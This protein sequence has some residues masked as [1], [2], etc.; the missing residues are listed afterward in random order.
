MTSSTSKHQALIYKLFEKTNNKKVNWVFD[1]GTP[2]VD[3][4]ING[5]LISLEKKS[6]LNGEPLMVL[7]IYKEGSIVESFNDEELGKPAEITGFD[8]YWRY[9]DALYDMAYRQATGA[10]EVID[11]ILSGLDELGE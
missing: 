5:A 1:Q 4:F 9:M 8:S 6:N 3:T 7:L 10:D 11:I 2:S